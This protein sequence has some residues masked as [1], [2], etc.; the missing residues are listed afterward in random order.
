MKETEHWFG[1]AGPLQG[2]Y[3][4]ALM[5]P[6]RRGTYRLGASGGIC[7]DD[8]PLPRTVPVVMEMKWLPKGDWLPDRFGMN[9]TSAIQELPLRSFIREHGRLLCT[10]T[11]PVG[12]LVIETTAAV[13]KLETD[14]YVWIEPPGGWIVKSDGYCNLPEFE[15]LGSAERFTVCLRRLL[16]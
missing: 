5:E 11:V 8:G 4:P 9:I 16:G 1:V 10:M 7:K 13:F 6:L 12:E 15:R 2:K 3:R 14:G